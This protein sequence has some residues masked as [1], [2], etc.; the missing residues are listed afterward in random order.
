MYRE[1]GYYWINAF[2]EYCIAYWNGSV[3]LLVGTA[4]IVNENHVDVVSEK[5][6][7]PR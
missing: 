4:S 5:L 3:F 2:Q 6:E 1:P 7:I